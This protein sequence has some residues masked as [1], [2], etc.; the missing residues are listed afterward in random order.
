MIDI[1]ELAEFIIARSA[2]DDEES[3]EVALAMQDA[4]IKSVWRGNVSNGVVEVDHVK[5]F[6]LTTVLRTVLHEECA[7]DWS[8]TNEREATLARLL[9]HPW[10]H[11][12]N[13]KE[14]WRYDWPTPPEVANGS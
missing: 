7:T 14:E 2:E 13:F 11:H 1:R 10:R 9:A 5:A 12:P 8:N 4:P 3:L 6:S